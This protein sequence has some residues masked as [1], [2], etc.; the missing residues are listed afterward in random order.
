VASLKRNG[1]PIESTRMKTQEQIEQTL[2]ELFALYAGNQNA[3]QEQKKRMEALIELTC[4]YLEINTPNA[5]FFEKMLKE[6]HVVLRPREK[7]ETLKSIKEQFAGSIIRQMMGKID[8][9]PRR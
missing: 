2:I 3:P 7:E 5:M 8:L 9:P 4:F 1:Q 6:P